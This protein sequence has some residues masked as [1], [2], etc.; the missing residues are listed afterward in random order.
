MSSLDSITGRTQR[1]CTVSTCNVL[2]SAHKGDF[3]LQA[4]NLAP[5]LNVEFTA[6]WF[7]LGNKEFCIHFKFQ[8]KYRQAEVNCPA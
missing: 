3:G 8:G 5:F 6:K 4:I 7:S 2:C 1:I